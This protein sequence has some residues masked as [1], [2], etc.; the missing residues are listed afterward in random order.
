LA[1][2]EPC[3]SENLV[4][5]INEGDSPNVILKKIA[6]YTLIDINENEELLLKYPKD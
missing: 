5:Y 6:L 4:N 3:Q 2:K 1:A